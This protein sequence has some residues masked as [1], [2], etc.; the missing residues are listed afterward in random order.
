MNNLFKKTVLAF[1]ILSVVLPTIFSLRVVGVQADVAIK[2]Y[3]VLAPLPGTT[4]TNC[5]PNTPGSCKADLR[6]Y[7]P[8]LFNLIIGLAA[9]VAVGYII[10]GG[11]QYVTTDAIKGKEEGKEKIRNAI[12]GLV[13]VSISW[14]ILYTIN[15]RLLEFDLNIDA[16]SVPDRFG[17]AGTLT[18]GQ[19][20]ATTA[21]DETQIRTIL[22]SN[23]IGINKNPCSSTQLTNCTN[24]AGIPIY[25]LQGV[26]SLKSMCNCAL[27]ITGGTESGHQTHGV[28]LGQMDLS[29]TPSLN[30]YLSVPNPT[31]GQQVTLNIGGRTAKFTYEVAGGRSTG[32]H[33][34]VSF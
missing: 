4:T 20:G 22:A 23:N 18:P 31:N 28:G 5:D 14:L 7:I 25:A 21:I 34:H 3:P 2:E 19:V 27:V 17:P 29:P 12:Y 24:L 15:P 10:F 1:I 13:M 9:V 26:T 11:F 6:S 30:T 16:T 33:W 32:D 8:G